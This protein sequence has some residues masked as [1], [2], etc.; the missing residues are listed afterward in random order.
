MTNSVGFVKSILVNNSNNIATTPT[1]RNKLPEIRT[2]RN[3]MPLRSG[4]EARIS[5]AGSICGMALKR[6]ATAPRS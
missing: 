6:A 3:F 5:K 2:F 4:D 1:Y